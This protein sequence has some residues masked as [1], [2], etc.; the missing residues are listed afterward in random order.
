MNSLQ[1]LIFVLSFSFSFIFALGGIGSAAAIIPVLT[2]VGVPF[3]IARPT[4][5]FINTLSMGG[6]TYSN[7]KGGRLDFKLG[8]PVII[9]SLVMAPI[10]A[11][12]GHFFPTQYLM[13]GL[14][15]FLVFAS[16]MMLFFRG[17]KGSVIYREDHPFFGP[18]LV[19]VLAGFCSGLLGVGGGGLISP[20][21]IM[22]GF[23]PKKI[24]AITA[25]AVPFSSVAGFITY[26]LMGSVAW[27]IWIVAGVAA[28]IGGY[29]GTSVMHKRMEPAAV[30]KF[31]GVI[32]FVV[33]MRILLNMIWR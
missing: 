20:L 19:G 6:A 29:F 4:G 15:L 10:G 18:A 33:A 22:Q 7:I 21:L 23:N 13:I 12:S 25:F 5:L 17:I 28:C 2:W 9:T 1:V 31:L 32:L 8:L 27:S 16:S 3:N 11:W 14:V 24:A 30:K 26:A